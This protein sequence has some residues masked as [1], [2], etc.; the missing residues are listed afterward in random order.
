MKESTRPL[1][2]RRNK[3]WGSVPV[4]A[5]VSSSGASD[6]EGREVRPTRDAF[7]SLHPPPRAPAPTKEAN[8]KRQRR[9]TRVDLLLQQATRQRIW[10]Q[11]KQELGGDGDRNTLMYIL[12]LQGNTEGRG[13]GGAGKVPHPS[14]PKLR[15]GMWEGNQQTNNYKRS[16]NEGLETKRG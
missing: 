8:D 14:N 15:D 10:Q 16:Y 5:P 3:G 4:N 13:S 6:L 9:R 2:P 7:L 1:K 11:T 12:C